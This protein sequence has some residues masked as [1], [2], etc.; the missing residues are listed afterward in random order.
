MAYENAY[1]RVPLGVHFRMD[2]DAGIRL[3]EL[4]AQRILELPWKRR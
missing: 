2:C 4:A 1:S 3:G